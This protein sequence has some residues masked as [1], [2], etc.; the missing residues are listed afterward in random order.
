MQKHIFFDQGAMHMAYTSGGLS[1]INEMAQAGLID[2]K[3]LNAWQ[4]IDS[5]DPGSISS[6]NTLLL[7]REQNQI[8]EDQYDQMRNHD[9]PVGDVVTYL[10]TVVGSASIPGT[11]TPGEYSPLT[12]SGSVSVPGPLWPLS[13]ETV[14]VKIETPLP[15]FNISDKD[16]RW[17]YVINDTLPA[18]QRLLREHPDQ[19]RAIIATPVDDR[20]DDQRL[21]HRWPQL[22][23]NGLLDW[24]VSVNGDIG[25]GPW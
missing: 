23:E 4:L 17:D 1:S 22:V 10:M 9:G 11:K 24:D 8:I 12:I 18:Y 5:G 3:A 2:S 25:W 21:A 20:I 13:H 19:A 14:G 16:S 7:D 6:G 15:D